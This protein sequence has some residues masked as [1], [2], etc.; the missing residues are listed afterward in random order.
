MAHD[1]FPTPTASSHAAVNSR[2]LR[3]FLRSNKALKIGFFSAP[4]LLTGLLVYVTFFFP[5]TRSWGFPYWNDSSSSSRSQSPAPVSDILT[6][7][8]IR[9]IVVPTR[10]FFSRDYS[11]YLGWNNVSV[12]LGIKCQLQMIF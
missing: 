3:L 10:G 12:S 9:D 8:Q 6:L 1:L 7:E 4:F 2:R 11:L 5:Q